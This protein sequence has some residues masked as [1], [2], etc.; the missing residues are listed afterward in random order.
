MPKKPTK[1]GMKVYVLADSNKGYTYNWR[2]YTGMSIYCN[3]PLIRI[4]RKYAPPPLPPKFLHRVVSLV[5]TPPG[6]RLL[7]YVNYM[8]SV[9]LQAR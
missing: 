9:T 1:W 6:E 2:L 3:V 7:E 8:C 4:L 5:I